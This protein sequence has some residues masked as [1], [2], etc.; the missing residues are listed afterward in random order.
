MDREAWR[1]TVHRAAKNQTGRKQLSMHCKMCI[2]VFSLPA[3]WAC[4]KDENEA[5]SEVQSL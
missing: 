5:N 1:A 2:I 3:F 4:G